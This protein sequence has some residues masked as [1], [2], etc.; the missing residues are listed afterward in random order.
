MLR[1]FST[2]NEFSFEYR[3]NMTRRERSP[4]DGRRLRHGGSAGTHAEINALA[5]KAPHFEPKAKR[6]IH[7]FLNGGPSQV[8]TFD[9]KPALEQVARQ[10]RPSREPEDGAE[11]GQP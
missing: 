2:S 9:P 5:V 3:V 1:S 8:D 7:L 10:A 11:D 6:V 4:G